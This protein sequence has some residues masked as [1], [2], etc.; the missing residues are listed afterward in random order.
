MNNNRLNYVWY[1]EK[2]YRHYLKDENK[3]INQALLEDGNIVIYT[4]LTKKNKPFG[5]WGDYELL[6][7]GRWHKVLN[8]KF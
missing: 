2:Q 8:K 5:A 3:S 7:R 1:S 4:E 6:G